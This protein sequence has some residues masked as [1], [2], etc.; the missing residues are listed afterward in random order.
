MQGPRDCSNSSV[1][2]SFLVRME[3]TT[4]LLG[5][6]T[7]FAVHPDRRLPATKTGF[8]AWLRRGLTAARRSGHA[9]PP[10]RSART[11]PNCLPPPEHHAPP[12]QF[13]QEPWFPILHGKRPPTDS[14]CC[15]PR[16]LQT[17]LYFPVLSSFPSSHLR[18][19]S[20]LCAEL[21]RPL[22]P[23]VRRLSS[24][25]PISSAPS[26]CPLAQGPW[27]SSR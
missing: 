7:R 11:I 2:V 3:P 17:A 4:H 26:Y 21:W 14:L 1:L 12:T 25:I 19:S 23:D 15:R 6:R 9:H 27:C 22:S 8:R 20:H 18:P 10:A 13:H 24:L 5:T 16:G